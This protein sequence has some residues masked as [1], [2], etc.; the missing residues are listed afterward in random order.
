MRKRR[1]LLVGIVML[2]LSLAA[3]WFAR[4]VDWICTPFGEERCSRSVWQAAKQS[5][6]RGIRSRMA[7]DLIDHYLLVAMSETQA[8]FLLGAPDKIRPA[9]AYSPPLRHD[10][11][12]Y[13]MGVAPLDLA[14]QHYVLRLYFDDQGK[15][16]RSEITRD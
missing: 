12:E 6:G 15:Y 16:R 13:D 2:P 9:E 14:G 3:C 1:Y 8:T 7:A 5:K 11:F 4:A 10:V